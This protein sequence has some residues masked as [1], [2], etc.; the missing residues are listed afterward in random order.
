MYLVAPRAGA[1]VETRFSCSSSGGDRAW[2]HPVRVR[3]L[4]QE[5]LDGLRG[6]PQSHPVR[7]RGLKPSPSVLTSNH[8]VAHEAQVAPRAGAWVETTYGA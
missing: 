8:N 1:W 6:N 5:A 3:G 2:S 4:K 7:V